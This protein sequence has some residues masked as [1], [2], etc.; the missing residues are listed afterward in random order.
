MQAIFERILSVERIQVGCGEITLT[1][2]RP[3][4]EGGAFGVT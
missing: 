2:E 4:T 3:Q 1:H